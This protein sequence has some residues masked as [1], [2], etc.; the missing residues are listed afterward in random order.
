MKKNK[1][2]TVCQNILMVCG[3]ITALT[4]AVG[5]IKETFFKGGSSSESGGGG[6]SGSTIIIEQRIQKGG[7]GEG[8]GSVKTIHVESGT[9]KVIV[10]PVTE[11]GR[12]PASESSGSSMI[13]DS[14]V[15]GSSAPEKKYGW[16]GVVSESWGRILAIGL[17]L[18]GVIV[19][20]DKYVLKHKVEEKSNE[21]S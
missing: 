9:P 6:N 18:M 3:V 13:A 1:I 2:T 7:E 17:L 19:L 14:Q 20:I 4:G 21:H 16:V 5:G 8:G 10:H 11:S 15:T 12:T